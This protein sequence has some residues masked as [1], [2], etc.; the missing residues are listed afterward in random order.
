MEESSDL[1]HRI[2]E[3]MAGA[4]HS[5]EAFRAVPADARLVEE[6]SAREDWRCCFRRWNQALK[7]LHNM[8]SLQHLLGT[9]PLLLLVQ[10]LNIPC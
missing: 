8:I 4:V 3:L 9:Q 6:T 1:R 2:H 7:L 5:F 10:V